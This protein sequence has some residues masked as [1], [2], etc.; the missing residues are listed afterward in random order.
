MMKSL[1]KSPSIWRKLATT[2]PKS[3]SSQ[4]Q[5]GKVITCLK[6]P[7]TSPGIRDLLSLK[8]WT[9]LMLQ[10]DPLTSHWDYP[11]RMFTRSVVL[12][13]SQSEESKPVSWNPAWLLFS[14]P[15]PYRVKLNPLKCTTKLSPKPSPETMSDSMLNLFPSRNSREGM[16]V[17]TKRMT[18][19]EKA[20]PSLLK[21]SSLTTLAKSE[22]V[23]PQC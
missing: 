23:I 8:L 9:L 18:L 7:Q 17:L 4:F 6:N 11:Y 12:E 13:L 2:Q 1:R 21:L 20:T 22:T 14:L 5:D 3:H 10:R 15:P 16:S 19:P